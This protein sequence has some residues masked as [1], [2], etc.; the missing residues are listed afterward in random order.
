MTPETINK[1]DGFVLPYVLCVILVLSAAGLIAVERLK[2]VTQTVLLFEERAMAQQALFTAEADAIFSVI[3]G[4]T[5]RGGIGINPRIPLPDAL[6][7]IPKEP[8]VEFNLWRANGEWRQSQTPSGKVYVNLQ[9]AAGLISLNT[10]A[11]SDLIETFKFLGLDS[12]QAEVITARLLDYSDEDNNRRFRGAERTDYALKKRSSPSNS[13]IRNHE[14]LNN[15]LGWDDISSSLSHERLKAFTTLRLTG[16]VR[17]NFAPTALLQLVSDK[18][19]RQEQGGFDIIE[20]ER[21][22]IFPSDYSRVKFIYPLPSGGYTEKVIEI[23][24]QV[25]NVDKPFKLF[26]VYEKNWP[27]RLQ[28]LDIETGNLKNAIH[29]TSGLSR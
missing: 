17:Y 23:R 25:N 10:T 13:P 21:Q 28:P 16:A 2:N 3:S 26:W 19:E 29:P 8:S 1:T 14:E 9:D 4:V 24:R 6:G 27:N 7:D 5:M 20:T 18:R 15:I 12:N 22:S 11:G